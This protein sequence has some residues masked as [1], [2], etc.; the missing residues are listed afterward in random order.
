MS[1]RSTASCCQPRVDRSV[2]RGART[3]RGP[4]GAA[5]RVSVLMAPESIARGE[6]SAAMHCVA[7]RV[8][9]AVQLAHRARRRAA[10]S[11]SENSDTTTPASGRY[12]W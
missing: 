10:L 12:E 1:I 4:E 3:G 2:P 8:R 7:G 5:P 11:P 6:A 9:S